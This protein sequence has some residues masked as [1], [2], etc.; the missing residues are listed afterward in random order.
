MGFVKKYDEGNIQIDLPTSNY[1]Y[2]LPLLS[3]ADTHGGLDLT[4]IFNRKLYAEGINTFSILSGYKLNVQKRILKTSNAPTVYQN[5]SGKLIALN[6]TD[7]AYAFD[8][9]TQ[10]ILRRTGVTH[11]LENPDFSKERFDENGRIAAVIDKYGVTVLSY[12]YNVDG[13]L[14]SITYRGEKT[15]SFTYSGNNISTIS[16]DGKVTTFSYTGTGINVAHYSGTTYALAVSGMNFTATSISTENGTQNT[17][18]TEVTKKS[19][20]E[21]TVSKLINNY[22]V[23]SVTYKFP[24]LVTSLDTQFSQ[25]E[26]TGYYGKTIRTHFKEDKALYSYELENSDVEFTNDKYIKNVNVYSAYNNKVK[27]FRNFVQGVNDG[28]TLTQ[29][30]TAIDVGWSANLASNEVDGCYLL[31]GWIRLPDATYTPTSIELDIAKT[32]DQPQYSFY[33]PK[34]PIGQ[35]SYFAV[36]FPYA[37]RSFCAFITKKGGNVETKDFRLSFQPTE[38]ATGDD[39]NNIPFSEDVLI[40][41]NSNTPVYFPISDLTFSCG[42]LQISNPADNR[43]VYFEDILKFKINQLKSRNLTEFYVNKA[44]K[45]LVLSAFEDVKFNYNGANYKLADCYLGRRE[46]TE[47]GIITTRLIDDDLPE[48]VLCIVETLDGQ[49]NVIKSYII[50]TTFDVQKSTVGNVITSYQRSTDGLLTEE[51]N[52]IYVRKTDYQKENGNY[53]ITETDEFGNTTIYRMDGTWGATTSVTLP[54]NTTITYAYDDDKKTLLSQT[55]TDVNGNSNTCALSYK[56]GYISGI[57]EG[58][59]NYVLVIPKG[60]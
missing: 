43:I 23:D 40:L 13:R 16:Y 46:Y 7:T 10:R 5:E 4:L 41:K 44:K 32:V 45:I 18:V 51:S 54:N 50:N 11:E 56:D 35:W 12:A 3:I 36:A 15:I 49:N 42:S 24:G 27:L 17:Y 52:N 2:E 59:L 57:E 22:F 39:S 29:A 47:S 37:E 53:K 1:L 26:I 58:S 31:S 9:D 14:A 48:K 28:V 34:A 55:E 6:S 33:L 8:D 38:V 19:D 21:L 20:Y 60:R 25:V 30:D